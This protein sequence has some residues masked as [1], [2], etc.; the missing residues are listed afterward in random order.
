MFDVIAMRTTLTL[1]ADIAELLRKEIRGGRASL[2]ATVNERLRMGYGIKQKPARR[3]FHVEPHGSRFRAGVDPARLNQLA[4]ELEAG[5]Q[6][7][8]IRRAG[9]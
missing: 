8:K 2:K 5:E 7:A 6:A 4:D 1:D 9:K 3:R